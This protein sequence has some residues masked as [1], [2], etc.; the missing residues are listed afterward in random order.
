ME[1]EQYKTAR[2]RQARYQ[3]ALLLVKYPNAGPGVVRAYAG[4]SLWLDVARAHPEDREHWIADLLKLAAQ[5]NDDERFG[6][7]YA[8]AEKAGW[9]LMSEFGPLMLKQL[10]AVAAVEP[11]AAES[12][13]V[14]LKTRKAMAP[15]AGPRCRPRHRG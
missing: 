4:L 2:E 14:D 9:R 10:A 8:H 3:E 1:M 13:V 5:V 6:H 12:K 7:A 15:I 11:A